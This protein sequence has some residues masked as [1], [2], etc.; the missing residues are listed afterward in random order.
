MV[1]PVAA[2][3]TRI[4]IAGGGSLLALDRF[5]W[6]L[7]GPLRL[8]CAGHR[9]LLRRARLLENRRAWN[10]W[11]SDHGDCACSHRPRLASLRAFKKPG[12]RSERRQHTIGTAASLLISTEGQLE[13]SLARVDV[14]EPGRT[15]WWARSRQAPINPR[16]LGLLTGPCRSLEG[17]L[18]RQRRGGEG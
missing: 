9:G 17:H 10:G 18:D 16:D 3:L 8:R 12:D 4:T 13:L 14:P 1:W 6:G 2:N 15:R 7:L 5:G 11:K